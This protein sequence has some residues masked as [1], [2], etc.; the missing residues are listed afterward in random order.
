[1]LLLCDRVEERGHVLCIIVE[2]VR[3]GDPERLARPE[4]PR[5]HHLGQA[6]EAVEAHLLHHRVRCPGRID[7]PGPDLFGEKRGPLGIVHRVLER[8]PLQKAPCLPGGGP[9]VDRRSDQDGIGL[10]DLPEDRFQ[11]VLHRAVPVTLP[12]D[13]LAGKA[14][15]A[16]AVVQVVEVVQPGFCPFRFCA[17]HGMPE[18]RCGVPLL[19]RA[20]V[21]GKKFHRFVLNAADKKVEC[22]HSPAGTTCHGKTAGPGRNAGVTCRSQGI[23]IPIIPLFY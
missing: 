17:L 8:Q 12:A 13:A 2:L 21:E 20:P 5:H 22:S 9:E 11:V 4:D 15:G 23:P 14:A 1:M 10:P 7:E 19:P 18:E 6:R 16:A 3:V